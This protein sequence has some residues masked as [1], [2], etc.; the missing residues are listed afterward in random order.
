M[1]SPNSSAP[2]SEWS[3]NQV[4]KLSGS[5]CCLFLLTLFCLTWSF[6]QIISRFPSDFSGLWRWFTTL[7]QMKFF[8]GNFIFEVRIFIRIKIY[9][10]TWFNV[11]VSI[12]LSIKFYHF[13]SCQIMQ[14]LFIPLVKQCRHL[15]V[16]K[17][18]CHPHIWGFDNQFQPLLK[19]WLT[20]F[21]I[22]L[23]YFQN[24]TSLFIKSVYF[25]LSFI[26]IYNCFLL[27]FFFLW[28]V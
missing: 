12:Y 18:C 5:S 1:T 15:W 23:F 9:S 17:N 21:V 8:E 20:E 28:Q 24:L 4:K 10:V 11:Y 25:I 22:F 16:V 26:N 6:H 19:K 13:N 2:A 7:I 27:F 3:V 14:H